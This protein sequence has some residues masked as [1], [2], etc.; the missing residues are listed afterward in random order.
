M[1]NGRCAKV[2]AFQ[3]HLPPAVI[4]AAVIALGFAAQWLAWR[5][6]L[7]AILFLLSLGL[8]LGPGVGWV[9]PDQ[10]LGDLLLPLVS[11]GVA[12]ILFEGSLTL[13]LAEITGH[14]RMIRNLTTWGVALNW[15]VL[16][17]G[18]RFVADLSWPLAFLIGA[19]LAVT[20]PTVISPLLRSVRPS[21]R[22]GNALRW[23]GIVVD[24]IGAILAVL[25][26]EFMLSG[27]GTRPVQV[28]AEML[29]SGIVLGGV[30]ALALDQLIRRR[31]VPDYLLNYATLAT[32]LAVFAGSDAVVHESGLL[33]VTVMGIVLANRKD[34]DIEQIL[35]FKEHLATVLISVLFI[36]LAAR[37]DLWLLQKTWLACLGFLLFTQFI[38]RPL[39]VLL[40]R[41]GTTFSWR[42]TAFLA[43]IAPRGIV[44]AAVSA[45]FALKLEQVGYLGAEKLVPLTF[46]IILGTVLIQSATAAPLARW[47]GVA[48]PR[49]RG[50]LLVGSNRFSR[51]LGRILKKEGVPLLVLDPD[52][53]SVREARMADLPAFYGD[54]TDHRTER[55]LDL[56]GLGLLLALS[57]RSDLNALACLRYEPEFPGARRF[58]LPFSTLAPG[59]GPPIE[60]H[61]LARRWLGDKY[62]LSELEALIE[63]GYRMRSTKMTDAFGFSQFKQMYPEAVTLMALDAEGRTRLFDSAHPPATQSGWVLVSLTPPIPVVVTPKADDEVAGEQPESA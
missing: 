21:K 37:I 42:E 44:A 27:T 32:L 16:A 17:T 8:L 62:G 63:Q 41:V 5:L 33:A 30:G 10:L 2:L 52:W 40:C 7:P 38:A 54:P 31:W 15:V 1:H 9:N 35:H 18:A 48:E 39:M 29:L 56:S 61:M 34:L 50:I 53:N 47:L 43:W 58:F 14:H 23:E 51:E 46:S 11:L 22:V 12:I 20:G 24:P 49:Q 26:F 13:R 6:K 57:H 36:L 28:L 45:L 4:V 59:E 19:I 3:M 60:R 25:V 55:L